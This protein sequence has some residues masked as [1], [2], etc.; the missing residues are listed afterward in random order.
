MALSGDALL[1]DA[2]FRHL[3][4]LTTNPATSIAWPGLSDG[5]DAPRL[6]VQFVPNTKQAADL[7]ISVDSPGFL[8][9]TV[10]VAEGKGIIE[11]TNIASQ[12]ADHFGDTIHTTEHRIRF[13]NPPSTS[14]PLPDGSEIRVP[15]SIPFIATS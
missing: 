14:Q 8:V 15:V 1:A 5:G 2:L 7:E 10:V 4:T 13:V 9:V 11:A 6:E 12:V 3:S